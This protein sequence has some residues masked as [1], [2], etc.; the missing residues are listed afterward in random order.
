MSDFNEQA[1][2]E[3]WL[4][5]ITCDWCGQVAMEFDLDTGKPFVRP[6]TRCWRERVERRTGYVTRHWRVWNI[7][8]YCLNVPAWASILGN[9]F[10]P[11]ADPQ[12][13]LRVG[14]EHRDV[15]CDLLGHGD[16]A[17]P[18][19]TPVAYMPYIPFMMTPDVVQAPGMRRLKARWVEEGAQPLE[20]GYDAA[21]F[22]PEFKHHDMKDA[23]AAAL[24]HVEQKAVEQ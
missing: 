16:Q 15:I 11:G 13:A 20:V 23:L 24:F 7:C 14:I 4:E 19:P 18:E 10:A 21:I 2:F 12:T 5:S 1:Y 8:Q 6:M 9:A 17:R 3:R 22:Y